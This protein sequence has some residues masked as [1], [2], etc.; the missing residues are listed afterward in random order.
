MYISLNKK[1]PPPRLEI[2]GSDL[3]DIAFASVLFI[4]KKNTNQLRTIFSCLKVK[5]ASLH[6]LSL[7]EF[8]S[9]KYTICKI[10]LLYFSYSV[11]T[12][13]FRLSLS[14]LCWNPALEGAQRLLPL[15]QAQI[16]LISS[17]LNS[18]PG[19]TGIKSECFLKATT[20]KVLKRTAQKGM[21]TQN[22]SAIKDTARP[23][24]VPVPHGMTRNKVFSCSWT[25][26][27]GISF[28]SRGA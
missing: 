1:K 2:M 27:P 12:W 16:Y 10:K 9:V 8:T 22:T 5:I 21:Y 28:P 23:T 6:C 7:E 11:W 18:H 15:F 25:W 4:V 19:T 3:K 17:A 24:H 26:R 13:A 20:W 14:L